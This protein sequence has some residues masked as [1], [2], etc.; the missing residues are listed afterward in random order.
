MQCVLRMS[1]AF[2]GPGENTVSK[3]KINPKTGDM[4]EMCD[5][6]IPL[7]V[8]KYN[9]YMGGLDKSDQYITMFY[10]KQFVTGK[11]YFIIWQT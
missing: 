10:V 9:K 4:R 2:P 8:E 7:V 6:T 5:I 3:K 11:F 1:S